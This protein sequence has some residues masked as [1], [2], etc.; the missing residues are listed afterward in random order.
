MC[1]FRL[2]FLSTSDLWTDQVVM[3]YQ[4][5]LSEDWILLEETFSDYNKGIRFYFDEITGF[6]SDM[7]ISDIEMELLSA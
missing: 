3:E 4:N 7:A 2:Q 6:E 1:R 5:Q